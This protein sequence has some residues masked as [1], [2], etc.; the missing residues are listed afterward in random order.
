LLFLFPL[1]L[2]QLSSST[3]T[4]I[5]RQCAAL[6]ENWIH[7]YSFTLSEKFYLFCP[8]GSLL[9]PPPL[10]NYAP[11]PA[12]LWALFFSLSCQDVP[13]KIIRFE[14][15]HISFSSHILFPFQV[16]LLVIYTYMF[17]F[18]ILSPQLFFFLDVYAG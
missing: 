8:L 12:P 14:Y 7:S 18:Q 1:P 11:P 10:P 16:Q 13:K 4:V 5:T 6:S 9:A 17:M 15:S 3:N 2:P